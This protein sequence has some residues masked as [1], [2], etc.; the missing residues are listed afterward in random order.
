VSFTA[1][2]LYGA[3]PQAPS[4][5]VAAPT[6]QMAT[7]DITSGWKGLFDPNNPLFW[8]GVVLAVT[9]GAAGVA[10][11]V[12]LGRAKLSADLDRA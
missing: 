10:G 12:R 7:D 9:L 6:Q 11:S 1:A 3:T 8:F 5:G 4:Y 2:S